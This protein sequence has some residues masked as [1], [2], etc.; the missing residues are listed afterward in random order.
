MFAQSLPENAVS[1]T[2]RALHLVVD[3]ALVLEFGRRVIEL[4]EFKS[5][6]FLCEVQF[7]ETR[8]ECGVKIDLQQIIEI[9]GVFTG[10]RIGSPIA[11]CE[12][13]HESVERT[14]NHHKKGIAYRI[15]LTAAHSSMF[16]YMG[17]AFRISW[18]STKTH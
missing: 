2:H 3:D 14:P 5:M 18:N 12:S 13:I 4:C 16:E 8:K 10:K 7:I 15:F 9:F 17:N 1:R 11:T 6:T